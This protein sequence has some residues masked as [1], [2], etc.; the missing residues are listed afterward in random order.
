MR[1]AP[2]GG[3]LLAVALAAA[4]AAAVA[5]DLAQQERELMETH[6]L[7]L[8]LPAVQAPAALAPGQLDASLE[9]VTIPFIDG[10]DGPRHEITASDHTRVFPRPRLMLGLPAPPGTRAFVGLSYIP[11]VRVRSVTTN[12]V[13]AE[14][15]FGVTPG[16]F[17]AALR[18]HGTYADSRAPVT[19]PRTRDRL[20]TGQWGAD[21]AAGVH[22]RAGGVVVE[23]YA[24]LGF[25]QVSSRFRVVVDGTVLRRTYGSATVLG[26]VRARLGP[27]WE[28]VAELDAYPGRLTHADIRLGYLFGK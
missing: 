19:D 25:V 11:P 16:R 6:S 13:G 5:K 18:L 8:D 24:G 23:P 17:R 27:R 9:A 28:V 12:F 4:P 7:L 22:L 10:N 1:C 14:A 15:G 26:G 21:V 2:L 20:L 3:T